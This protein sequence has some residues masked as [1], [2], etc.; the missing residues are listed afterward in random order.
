MTHRIS[1][2]LLL[3]LAVTLA[4]CRPAVE[5]DPVTPPA[6]TPVTAIPDIEGSGA[7]AEPV[8][9]AA[10]EA[11]TRPGEA[12]TSCPEIARPGILLFLADEQY[13]LFDPASG[14][15]CP[16]AF[17]EPPIPG[18][19]A[20]AQDEI[21]LAGH[22]MG[23]DGEATVISRYMPDGTVEVLDYTLVDSGSGATLVAFT[24]SADARLIAW[25]VLGPV[26][27]TE[28]PSPGLFI[29]DLET[30]E[31][32]AQIAP[33]VGQAPRAPEPIRFSEDGSTL[34]YALQPYGLGGLWSSYAGR[35][36]NLYTV[37]TDGT[38]TPE[39][40]FDCAELA[41]GLCLGDFLVVDST[42]T[43]L[44]YTDRETG[45]VVIQNGQGDVLNTVKAEEEYVGYPTWGS[46]GELVY[47]AADLSDDP[48]VSTAPEMGFLYRLAPP[49]GPAELLANDAALL[50]PVRFVDDSQIAATWAGENGVRGFTLVGVDGTVEM[51]SA[52]ASATLLGVPAVSTLLGVSGSGGIVSTP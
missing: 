48:N 16:L 33:E 39:L 46:S 35:Y 7:T 20:T 38:G 44:A 5:T 43:G 50:L 10:T 21:Y 13:A 31:L 19:V 11:E 37:A 27:D 8:A 3:L 22:T 1:F 12:T 2:F 52:P 23:P 45:T 49:T 25:S 40:I 4:A 15:S 17:A 28:M 34:Y 26:S 32:L 29:A 51:P 18:L 36:D 30:G 14:E 24:V 47:Y 9:T 6:G 42:V 41:Q